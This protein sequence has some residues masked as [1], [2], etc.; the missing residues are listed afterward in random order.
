[1]L[2][3][4]C[5]VKLVYQR[6][7][8]PF[9]KAAPKPDIKAFGAAFE[10][11]APLSAS[12]ADRQPAVDSKREDQPGQSPPSPGRE[13]QLPPATAGNGFQTVPLEAPNPEDL[14]RWL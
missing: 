5:P 13:A 6:A 8:A 3:D 12:D 9:H 1:M 2:T 4:C 11:D 10:G 7:N 14:S